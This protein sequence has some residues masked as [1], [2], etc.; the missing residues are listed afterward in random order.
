M[1]ELIGRSEETWSH[2]AATVGIPPA[3][4]SSMACRGQR[5]LPSIDQSQ[6]APGIS[7]FPRTF[8]PWLLPVQR[9]RPASCKSVILEP[10]RVLCTISLPRTLSCSMC[11]FT[12]LSQG[13]SQQFWSAEWSLTA[14]QRCFSRSIDWLTWHWVESSQAWCLYAWSRSC[15]C[16]RGLGCTAESHL[17]SQPRC[18]LGSIGLL[19]A[20]PSR[21][22]CHRTQRRC[23]ECHPWDWALLSW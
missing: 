2:S 11:S 15:G 14:H 5:R 22:F 8:Q 20:S 17:W 3:I 18:K 1:R 19:I 4:V 21:D 6:C 23:W 10:I 16:M 9:C 13:R 7:A 12:T